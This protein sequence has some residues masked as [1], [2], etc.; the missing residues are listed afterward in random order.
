MSVM[1][2]GILLAKKGIFQLPTY[3][4][5]FTQFIIVICEV[6]RKFDH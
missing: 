4:K 2:N 6:P 5:D 3:D 1:I